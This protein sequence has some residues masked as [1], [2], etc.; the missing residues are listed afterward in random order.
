METYERPHPITGHSW[1]CIC[2][3]CNDWYAICKEDKKNP[4]GHR[5]TCSCQYCSEICS[6]CGEWFETRHD[7]V[8]YEGWTF[9]KHGIC[10]DCYDGK[11]RSVVSKFIRKWINK[12]RK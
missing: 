8:R 6:N 11:M 1:S 7:E 10:I 9:D 4:I 5:W 2:N 12:T 3:S